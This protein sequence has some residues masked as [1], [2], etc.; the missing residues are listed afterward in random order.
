MGAGFDEVKAGGFSELLPEFFQ[1]VGEDHAEASADA[2]AGD[3]V[4]LLADALLV[5]GVVAVH[6]V[7]EGGLH[8]VGKWDRPVLTDE[9][10][11]VG[12]QGVWCGLILALESWCCVHRCLRLWIGMSGALCFGL[13]ITEHG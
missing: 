9:L 7:V 6:R 5:G 11:D 10:L 13:L 12:H 4:A 1:A 3:E 2:D 8:V